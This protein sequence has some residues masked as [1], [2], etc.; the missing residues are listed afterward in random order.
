[1]S[2][3]NAF[4]KISEY[5]INIAKSIYFPSNDVAWHQNSEQLPF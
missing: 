4:G 1:M 5:K 3:L 2:E